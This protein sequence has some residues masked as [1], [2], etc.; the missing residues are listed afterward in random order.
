[1]ISQR[2]GGKDLGTG[3]GL[4][5]DQ[6]GDAIALGRRG[7]ALHGQLLLGALEAQEQEGDLQVVGIDQGVEQTLVG[8]SLA[9]HDQVFEHALVHVDLGRK[10]DGT[11]IAVDDDIAQ[12]VHAVARL[13]QERKRLVLGR[14]R[15]IR[16]RLAGQESRGG[17]ECGEGSGKCFHGCPFA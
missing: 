1:L 3:A 9:V 7:V 15:G 8:F 16:R 10:G 17:K 11:G 14:R 12:A 13:F 2:S 4:P 5:A 6:D